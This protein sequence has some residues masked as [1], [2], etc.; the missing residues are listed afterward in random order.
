[1]DVLIERVC[2][3]LYSESKMEGKFVPSRN[4][5]NMWNASGRTRN[6]NEV[7]IPIPAEFREKYPDFFPGISNSFNLVLANNTCVSAKQCQQNGKALMSNPNK[8]LGKWLLREELG[9]PEKTVITYEMLVEKGYDSLYLEK[10]K[11]RI[12]T[13]YKMFMAPL[14]AYEL[15]IKGKSI[16]EIDSKNDFRDIVRNKQGIEDNSVTKGDVVVHRTLGKGIV[17]GVVGDIIE[18]EYGNKSLKFNFKWLKEHQIIQ[19]IK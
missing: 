12:E 3:P 16:S 7:G 2:L 17:I 11:N 4:N 19:V 13:Y 5:L 15:F 14:G 9:I 18:I 1:M 6:E 8:A 10:W